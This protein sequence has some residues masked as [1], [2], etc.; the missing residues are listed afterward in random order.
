M[1]KEIQD[2]LDEMKRII[3]SD[4]RLIKSLCVISDQHANIINFCKEKQI[5]FAQ[6]IGIQIKSIQN[7]LDKAFELYHKLESVPNMLNI[8]QDFEK[9]DKNEKSNSN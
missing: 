3:V 2:E 5:Q 1:D 6:E 4:N 8:L 7:D 9:L